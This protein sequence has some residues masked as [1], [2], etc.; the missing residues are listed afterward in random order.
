ME[1]MKYKCVILIPAKIEQEREAK[2]EKGI[3]DG[4]MREIEAEEYDKKISDAVKEVWGGSTGYE[5]SNRIR[6]D[7]VKDFYAIGHYGQQLLS[8]YK[9]QNNN[10][11][12]N[13]CYSAINADWIRNNPRTP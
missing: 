1:Q 5:D 8:W 9:Y 2:E 6:M 4:E 3:R 12:K 7:H 13:L 10:G 11:T